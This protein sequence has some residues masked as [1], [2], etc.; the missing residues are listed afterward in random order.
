MLHTDNQENMS[1]FHRDRQSTEPNLEMIQSC[2]Y[3][4]MTLKQMI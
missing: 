3:K 4:T 1:D 2:N